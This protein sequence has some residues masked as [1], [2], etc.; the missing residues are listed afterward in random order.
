MNF[1]FWN[2]LDQFTVLEAAY[3][4]RDQE[5]KTTAERP[6]EVNAMIRRL[7]RAL[8]QKEI[9]NEFREESKTYYHHWYTEKVIE[10]THYHPIT[11]H[12]SIPKEA[13]MAW[14]KAKG[15]RPAFLFPEE[16][17]EDTRER[18]TWARLVRVLCLEAGISLDQPYKAAAGLREAAARHGMKWPAKDATIGDKLKL[19]KDVDPFR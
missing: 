14:C 10:Q 15:Y 6:A 18:D 13:L 11:E 5:P 8:R 16:R 19:A 3:L 4:W 1:S 2:S 9:P 17:R 12:C 7:I